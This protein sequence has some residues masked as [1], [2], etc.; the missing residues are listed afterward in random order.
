MCE[1][2]ALSSRHPTAVTLSLSAFA[3]HRG[4]ADGWGVAF[5]D[6]GDVRLYKEPELAA[7]S[8]WLELIQQRGLAASLILAHIRHATRGHRTLANTQPFTRELG[9]RMH[10]FAHNGRFDSIEDDHAGDWRRFRPIGETDSE[11]AFCILLERMVPLWDGDTLPPLDLRL[12]TFEQFAAE[13]RALGPANILYWDGDTLFV[14][15]HRRIQGDGRVAA[16]GLWRL[17]RQCH[18]DSSAPAP[19][20]GAGKQRVALFASVPL[21]GEPWEPLD[22]G[23]VLALRH[24]RVIGGGL[25]GEHIDVAAV[26]A[27]LAGASRRLVYAQ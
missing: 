17:S 4:S 21:S 13:M 5:H 25:G 14:H 11:I 8:Q 24:G 16:P 15:G 6:T 20:T 12:A 1:L 7:E 18:C 9:G 10:V 22:E 2:L 23:A 27:T 3:Q 26:P 19:K